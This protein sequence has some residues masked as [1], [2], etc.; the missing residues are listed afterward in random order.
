MNQNE[1]YLKELIKTVNFTSILIIDK[2]GQI[3]R[4]YCPF[5]VKARIDIPYIQKGDIVIVEKIAITD[6]L[7]DVYM[8]NQKAYY[9]IYFIVLV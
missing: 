9:T 6:N 7:S 8:I 5:S 4:L 3:K 2:R 1:K